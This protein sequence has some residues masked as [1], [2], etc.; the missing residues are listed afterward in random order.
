MMMMMMMMKLKKILLFILVLLCYNNN[1]VYSL[2]NGNTI[3][4]KSVCIIGGGFGGLYTALKL[5]DMS[6]GNIAITL[7]DPKENF[8]FLPLLYELAINTASEIEVAP[9]Y[10]ELLKNSNIK[11]MKDIVKNIDPL[12]KKVTYDNDKEVCYDQIVLAVGSQPRLDI[13]PGAKE[14]SIPFYGINDAYNLQGKLNQ[15]L[16][17]DQIIRVVVIGGGYSG[18][19]VATSVSEYL[20]KR[21]A[22][23]TILDRNECVMNGSPDHNRATAEKSL[24]SYGISI[25]VNTDVKKVSQTAVT[26]LNKITNEEYDIPA[27]IVISTCGVQPNK[28]IQSLNL[29]KDPY[30]RILTTRT[31][32]S[33][34]YPNI[35]ALGDCSSI[36]NNALPSTA[37]VAMQQSEIVASN[38]FTCAKSKE[39]PNFMELENFRFVPLGEMLTLGK[40]DASVYSLGG[41]VTLDG[42]LAAMSRRLVYAFR[43]PTNNQRATALLN[44]GLSTIKSLISRN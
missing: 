30:G 12:T 37:Q 28:L 9:K 5:D 17:N 3:Y 14:F 31:L 38:V 11:F 24:L 34:E 8:V 2:N 21:N 19:E 43:M 10:D 40:V 36:N 20:T 18:V 4:K 27:D 32:Q 39:E 29:K 42:P 26:V 22:V 15:L 23:V 16:K 7:V 13:V 35:F 1:N 33:L 25:N 6:Q 41:L 44:S